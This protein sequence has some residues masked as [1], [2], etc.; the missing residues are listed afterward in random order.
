MEGRIGNEC[1]VGSGV[2]IREGVKIGDRSIIA[3]GQVV[4]NDLPPKTFLK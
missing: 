1:F 4:M 3:S 2:I